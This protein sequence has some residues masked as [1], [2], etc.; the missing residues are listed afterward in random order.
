MELLGCLQTGAYC[1]NGTEL[2]VRW[3]SREVEDR[4]R[5]I[6]LFTSPVLRLAGG[7]GGEGRE[8]SVGG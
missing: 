4:V 5:L 1:K 2:S 6:S 7:G 8:I 3:R